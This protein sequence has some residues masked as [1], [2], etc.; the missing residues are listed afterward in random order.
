MNDNALER[1]LSNVAALS[2][3]ET[4]GIR[5][6]AKDIRDIPAKQDIVSEG[7]RPDCVHM[8]LGGWAA[9]YKILFSQGTRQITAFPMPGD[10]CDLH[11]GILA[12]MGRQ[13]WPARRISIA[14]ASLVRNTFRLK[15]RW[16]G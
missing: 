3:Q 13:E 4:A 1:K 14:G 16:L 12:R 11:I 2:V 15:Q 5:H 6:F 9:R 10:F 7:E 8:I